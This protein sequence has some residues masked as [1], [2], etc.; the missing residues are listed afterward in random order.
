MTVYQVIEIFPFKANL[1]YH[2][3]FEKKMC[4]VF[5]AGE[6]SKESNQSPSADIP[7]RIWLQH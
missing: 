5:E 1:I 2:F 7:T 4:L 6:M 3:Y